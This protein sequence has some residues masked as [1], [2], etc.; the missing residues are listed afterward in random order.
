MGQ[1]RRDL[2]ADERRLLVHK[3]EAREELEKGMSRVELRRLDK[4][5]EKEEELERRFKGKVT[6]RQDV[7]GI[8]ELYNK[9][10]ILPL[11]VRLDAA[12]AALRYLTAPWWRRRWW[13]LKRI[14]DDR[15]RL[16]RAE[17]HQVLHVKRGGTRWRSTRKK[18]VVI[19]AIQGCMMRGT[20][21]L[22]RSGCSQP[23][24]GKMT[25]TRKGLST[26]MAMGK[27]AIRDNLEGENRWWQSR[28]LD[29]PGRGRRALPVQA[30]HLRSH[31]RTRR[32]GAA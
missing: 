25:P 31:L 1:E 3:P 14:G 12:E 10:K 23:G 27:L 29:H 7:M 22:R 26:E 30:R 18:P 17:G 16:A 5:T 8:I 13:D 21:S 28:R 24:G 4:T 20:V 9:S 11:A 32:R 15:A 6:T 19:E 2:T